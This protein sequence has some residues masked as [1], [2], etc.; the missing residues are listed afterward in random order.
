M[1]ITIVTTHLPTQINQ[2][3]IPGLRTGVF[4]RL[5]LRQSLFGR[6]PTNL[7]TDGT[8]AASSFFGMQPSQVRL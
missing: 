2:D 8:I 7:N 5:V 6:G 1:F 3:G 4:F